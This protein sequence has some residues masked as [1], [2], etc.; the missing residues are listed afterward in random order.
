M[1]YRTSHLKP[2]RHRHTNV[3]LAEIDD[4][5]YEVAAAERPITVRGIFYRVMSMGL[6]PKTDKAN[7]A[8]GEPS[9]YGIV[10]RETLKLRRAGE[11]PYHWITDGTRLR[12]Q[13]ETFSDAQ[14][15]LDNTARMYRRSLWIYQHAHI[16]VWA[17]KDAITGVVYPV[18]EQYDVPLLI[19]RGYSSETFLYTTAAEINDEG[20]PAYI[21]QLGDHDRD[22]VRAWKHI[23]RKL[24][25][26]VDDD[27]ELTFAR[28]AVTPDQITGLNLPT[29]P[30]KTD[31]GFGPCVEVDAIESNTLR[32]LVS[33][34]IESHIDQNALRVTKVAEASERELLTRIAAE[35]DSA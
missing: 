24:R 26:F 16:E 4:A 1:A 3:E 11:L 33:E 15:A 31:S 30:D 28:I 29:R 32:A 18:T 22:G 14:A 6:V 7:K 21:Y 23:S 13:P 17:E 5:I 19:A 10:Q 20:N 34:A 2:K 25:E 9:G 35:L 12:L 8:T 27:I